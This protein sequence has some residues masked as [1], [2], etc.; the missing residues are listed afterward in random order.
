MIT[1]FVKIEGTFFP[2]YEVVL[3]ESRS[4]L[5]PSPT[6]LPSPKA[7][8]DRRALNLLVILHNVVVAEIEVACGATL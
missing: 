1:F 4:L 2:E 5:C 8:Y 6:S 3:V 7:S